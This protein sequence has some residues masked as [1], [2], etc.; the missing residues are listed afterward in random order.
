MKL[1]IGLINGQKLIINDG[2]KG[3]E[4]IVGALEEELEFI[5]VNEKIIVRAKEIAFVELS[6]ND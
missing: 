6:D 3:F 2:D 5:G 1:I 4:H